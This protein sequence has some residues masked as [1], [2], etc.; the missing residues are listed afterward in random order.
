M[1]SR[2]QRG[3]WRLVAALLSLAFVIRVAA[4]EYLLRR[5]E[6][7]LP[8]SQLYLAYAQS[9]ERGEGYRVGEDFARRSPGYPLF[10]AGCF[11]FASDQERERVILWSQALLGTVTCAGVF[12]IARLLEPQSLPSGSAILALGLATIEPY[13]IAIGALV[14]SE[15][16]FT[17]LLVLG[18]WVAI[19]AS[20]ATGRRGSFL[21]CVAG[22]LA[23]AAILVRPSAL[24]LVV[25]ASIAGLVTRSLTWRGAAAA[26]LGAVVVMAPWWIRNAL[27]LGRWVPTALNVGESLYDGLGPQATGASDTSFADEPAARKLPELERDAYWWRRAVEFA[28]VHPARS[29]QLAAIKFARFW[30][31]WPNEGRFRAPLVVVGTTSVTLVIAVG[32]AMALARSSRWRANGWLLAPSICFCAVHMVFVSSVRY[33]MPTTPFLCVLAGSGFAWWGSTRRSG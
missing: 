10:L 22:V 19:G 14:L 29:V 33:R 26:L 1:T 4:D 32:C 8:D 2:E 9:L 31:P 21:W 13:A 25:I 15:T 5:V 24:A 12:G 18:A 11:T 17:T 3:G 23:G 6:E 28:V 7:R 20:R 30:S 16:L 27:V